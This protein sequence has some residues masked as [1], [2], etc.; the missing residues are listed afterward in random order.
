MLLH[1]FGLKNKQT[2]VTLYVEM[3]IQKDSVYFVSIEKVK[4]ICF[5]IS[6]VKLVGILCFTDFFDIWLCSELKPKPVLKQQNFQ[7]AENSIFWTAL[8]LDY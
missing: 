3:S 6:D 2:E 4:V 5:N 1:F 7:Q 8:I